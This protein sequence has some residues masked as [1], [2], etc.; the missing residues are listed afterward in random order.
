MTDEGSWQEVAMGYRAKPPAGDSGDHQDRVFYRHPVDIPL[1]FQRAEHDCGS[2]TAKDI[3]FGGICFRSDERVPNNA[4][5]TIL[6]PSVSGEQEVH[7]RVVWCRR[8]RSQGWEIGAAFCEE[9]DHFRTRM[10]EQL[11]QI[12]LY[13]RQ[14]EDKEG[15]RLAMED[16]AREWVQR[17]A[18]S[19][20]P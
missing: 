5:I 17:Y 6:F 9:Y 2:G 3:G 15:R 1:R 10:V 7:A 16:A 20:P 4:T 13:R 11:F 18:A 19:F 8:Q 14:V 12:E